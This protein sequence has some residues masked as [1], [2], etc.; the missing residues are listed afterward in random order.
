[1]PVI[2]CHKIV[3]ANAFP[4]GVNQDRRAMFVTARDHEH[5]VPGHAVIAREGISGQ[6]RSDDLADVGRAFRIRPCHA[7]KNMFIHLFYES[8]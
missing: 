8:P 2:A 4:F 3:W 7:N 1:M 6:I 5:V